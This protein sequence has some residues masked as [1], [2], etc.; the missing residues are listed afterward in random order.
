MIEDDSPLLELRN[1]SVTYNNHTVLDD[2]NLSVRRGEFVVLHGKTGCGKSTIFQL[3]A[4]LI[5]PTQGEIIIAGDRID[6][7]DDDQRRWLRRSMG[8]MLQNDSMLTDRSIIENIMLP[9]LASDVPIKEA[10][11]RAQLA[12]HKCGISELANLKPASLSAGQKQLACLARAVINHPVLILAD[13]PVTHLD[14]NNAQTLLDLLGTF[15]TAGVTVLVASHQH[16]SSQKC[17]MREITL[18]KLE[19]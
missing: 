1:I 19:D 17:P 2:L 4:G 13:E 15:A 3:I 16:L 18:R 14:T 11:H 9:A 5:Q 7:Y 10:R 8:I 12:L 6:Q